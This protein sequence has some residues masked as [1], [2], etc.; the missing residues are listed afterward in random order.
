MDIKKAIE[1]IVEK[2]KGDEALQKQFLSDPAGALEKLTGI[3]LPTDQ[4]D[5]VV[6]GVKAKLTADNIGDAVKGLGSLFKK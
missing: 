1:D 5:A 2:I 4:L 3:D 6:S